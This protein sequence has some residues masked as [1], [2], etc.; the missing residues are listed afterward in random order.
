M[1]RDKIRIDYQRHF[2]Y[3]KNISKAEKDRIDQ[4]HL[5]NTLEKML[6]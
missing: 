1:N 2:S 3:I 6:L 4:R 5:L